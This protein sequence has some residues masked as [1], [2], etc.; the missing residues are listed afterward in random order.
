MKALTW[1][2]KHDIRRETVPDPKL[3]DGRDAIIKV[4]ACAIC[5]SD[6]HIFD[7]MIPQMKSGDVPVTKRLGEVV[8]ARGATSEPATRRYGRRAVYDRRG[9]CFFCKNGFYSGCERTN[10]DRKKAEQLWGHSPAGLFGYSHILGGYPGGQAEYLRVPY[11][12]VGPIRS[13]TDFS[14]AGLVP[15]RHLSDRLYGGGFLRP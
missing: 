8:E 6:L 9:E 7:G 3:Q 2:G 14:R 1:H 10:P 5:G 13:R 12:D 11:A 4:T 15:L